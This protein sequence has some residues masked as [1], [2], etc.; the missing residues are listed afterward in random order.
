TQPFAGMLADKYGSAR[1][2]LGGVG[3]YVL[4]LAMMAHPGAPWQCVRSA[5]L[6][7]GTGLSGVTFSVISGVLGRAFPPEKRSMALGISAAAGS[8]G[9]FA[10]LPLTP[11]LLSRVGWVGALMALGGVGLAIA[12]LAAAMIERRVVHAHVFQQ[13][14]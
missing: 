10:M 5:D 12:P 14:A 6:L 3:L 4:R 11:W 1:V 8:F 7:I 2:V 9:P 13:S